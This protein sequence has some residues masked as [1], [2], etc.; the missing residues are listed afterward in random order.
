MGRKVIN[1][2]NEVN[3]NNYGSKMEIIN[4]NRYTDI[5]VYFEEYDWIAKNTS[6]DLFKKGQISC[7]YEKRLLG[8]GYIGEGIYNGKNNINI[9]YQWTRMLQR[10]YDP[11]YINKYPTYINC[12]VCEEW[13]NFQNFA[14]WY[15]ENYYEI[16]NEE[17]A[18]DKDILYKGNKI[19][20]PQTC[21]FV[22]QRINSL[23]EK[24]NKTRG[25][26]PI[27]VSCIE[28]IYY[29]A[30]CRIKNRNMNKSKLINIGTFSNEID[31]F[32]AY[33]IFKEKYIKEVANEYKDLIPI[34]LYN[35]MH[36]WKV[37][38]ND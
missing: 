23:F 10:C 33:K 38:I 31:A 30:R 25:N 27:G 12:F 17:M 15:E 19:Y 24:C 7:P 36:D 3:F 29:V 20:S 21:I 14:K 34:E 2:L 11:Y 32:F 13:H 1:R 28:G 35:A 37:D 26:Y 9:Y 8:I 18:L 5:D 16:E 22:P 6:Y 4:C